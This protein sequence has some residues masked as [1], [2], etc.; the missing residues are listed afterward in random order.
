MS[1]LSQTWNMR[2]V[3]AKSWMEQIAKLPRATRERIYN[4]MAVA[5]NEGRETTTPRPLMEGEPVEEARGV[6]CI[7]NLKDAEKAKKGAIVQCGKPASHV[8]YNVKDGW[9][10]H[11]CEEH[12]ARDTE[13]ETEA[14][15]TYKLG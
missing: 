4:D 3:K 2:K 10:H 14:D 7:A 5:R 13:P 8:T 11:Y 9:A 15:Y 1:W 12:Q 6:T